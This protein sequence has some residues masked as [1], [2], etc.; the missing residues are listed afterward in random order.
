M[1]SFFIS[2]DQDHTDTGCA[3]FNYTN[4]MSSAGTSAAKA[5]ALFDARPDI[6]AQEPTGDVLDGEKVQGHIKF[7][8]VRFRY[9]TRLDTPVLQGLRWACA[10]ARRHS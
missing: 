8:D 4:D 1:V 3:V 2:R 10:F 5:I 7:E 9:P 6:D